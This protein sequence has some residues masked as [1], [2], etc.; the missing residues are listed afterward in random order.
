MEILGYMKNLMEQ[1]ALA[2]YYDLDL[3]AEINV[4]RYELT[5]SGQ[6]Q[7]SH[8]EGTHDDCLWALPLVVY[9]TRTPDTSYMGV[10]YGVSRR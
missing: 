10:D 7:F 8:P 1:N 5:K 9:A 4:E 6:I 2:L 3:I